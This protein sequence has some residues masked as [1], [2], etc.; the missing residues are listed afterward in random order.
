MKSI[1]M[2]IKDSGILIFCIFG[3]VAFYAIAG[4]FIFKA[5]ME[6]YTYFS[7]PAQGCYSMFI[8]LTTANFPDVMLPAYNANRWY[9]LYFISFLIIGLYFL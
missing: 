4:Y 8:L 7:T 6:G 2:L 1:F 9:C 3:Y 5:T